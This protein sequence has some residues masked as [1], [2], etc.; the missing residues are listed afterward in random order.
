MGTPLKP[1]VYIIKHTDSGDFYIG[2]TRNIDRRIKGHQLALKQGRHPNRYLQERFNTNPEISVTV[3]PVSDRNLGFEL[4]QRLLTEQE[5]NPHLL[6]I[7]KGVGYRDEEVNERTA[8][9]I[10][11]RPPTA[12]QLQALRD[13]SPRA[14]H[15]VGRKHTAETLEKMRNANTTAKQKQIAELIDRQGRKVSVRGQI[16][17]SA[18]EA[19]RA[20]GVSQPSIVR[21]CNSADKTDYLFI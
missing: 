2:S 5:L 15:W 14:Q 1:A 20:E 7:N 21:W 8:E 9:A 10:R 13:H 18:S 11:N 6:N 3:F 19:A 12:K 16:Y 17:A 4:E